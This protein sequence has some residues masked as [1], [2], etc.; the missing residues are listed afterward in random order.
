MSKTIVNI[1]VDTEFSTHLEDIGIIGKINGKQYGIPMIADL[2]DRYGLKAT[3]YVDVYTNKDEYTSALRTIC[4][5]LKDR[6]HDLQ[7]HT[8]PCGLFDPRREGMKD[9]NLNEQIEIIHKGQVL[10]WEWFGKVPIAHRAGDWFANENTLNAL[11]ANNIF[12]DSSLFFGWPNCQLN[13]LAI[14]QN[15]AVNYEGLLELPATSFRCFD[16]GLFSP[17]RLLSTDGNSFY[18]TWF[19]LKSMQAQGAKLI[20]TV[21]HS[22]SFLQWNNKRSQYWASSNRIRKF[23]KFLKY[24]SDDSSLEV[25]T[26]E[27]IFNNYQNKKYDILSDKDIIHKS[28]WE[29]TLLRFA[30]RY[31]DKRGMSAI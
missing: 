25:L 11:I 30:D 28:N 12:V 1:S 4:L 21:Y 9:Y 8:H 19:I 27:E 5:M 6:G 16:L 26:V 13:Q 17:Y 22:F 18:E 10:F 15:S 7:L 24:L 3:F 14:T 29:L 2:L 23:E 20:T 31:L